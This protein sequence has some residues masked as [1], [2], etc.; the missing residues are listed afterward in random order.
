MK[1][2]ELIFAV[3]DVLID[4]V[5]IRKR[6]FHTSQGVEYSFAIGIIHGEHF[7]KLPLCYT[8][9]EVWRGVL[10]LSLDFINALPRKTMVA[11][12]R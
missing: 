3:G 4:K 5:C 12:F 2:V 1:E 10:D 6:L 8:L 9:G 11:L 7:K